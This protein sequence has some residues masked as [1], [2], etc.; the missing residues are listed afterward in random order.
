MTSSS[1]AIPK[2]NPDITWQPLPNPDSTLKSCLTGL[3]NSL[4]TTR[5]T[6]IA[7]QNGFTNG[8]VK[9]NTDENNWINTCT[10]LQNV[11]RLS[12]FHTS[13]IVPHLQSV[14]MPL[15]VTLV[16]SIRSSIAKHSLESA[17]EL[18]N[19]TGRYI[20]SHV[21]NLIKS[22]LSVLSGSNSFLRDYVE[23]VITAIMRNCNSTK[24]LNGILASS[25]SKSKQVREQA[26]K[27]IY[28]FIN[29]FGQAKILRD[30]S[31]KI[32]PSIGNALTA[33]EESSRWWGKKCVTDL[34]VYPEFERAVVKHAGGEAKA[35]NIL[36]IAENLRTNPMGSRT[37]S[38]GFRPKAGQSRQRSGVGSERGYSAKMRV[39]EDEY[40]GG[41]SRVSSR[42]LSQIQNDNEGVKEL[43]G[44]MKRGNLE[45]RR[46]AIER[47]I[48]KCLSPRN[49]DKRFISD[50]ISPLA[51]AY[52]DVIKTSNNKVNEVALRGLQKLIQPH[53]NLLQAA[54]FK[55]HVP[56]LVQFIVP[57]LNSNSRMSS[58]AK[59]ADAALNILI[60]QLDC[61]LIFSPLANRL[62][63]ERPIQVKKV[64]SEKLISII[65]GERGRGV[66][67]NAIIERHALP[68]LYSIATVPQLKTESHELISSIVT[69]VG[70]DRIWQLADVHNKSSILSRLIERP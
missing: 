7:A 59:H 10:A 25:K 3:T 15:T 55:D 41:A 9:S 19:S 46:L 40:L 32:I 42:G 68:A 37:V 1:Q 33:A 34:M 18:C 48:D 39:K 49:E 21:E 43:T 4:E 62:Q 51:D 22:A 67:K 2:Y 58:L 8:V 17:E 60:D 52:I 23:R 5:E 63:F 31:D 27:S 14:I 24:F 26:A 20:D 50:N 28:D 69:M 65:Q 61:T 16:N 56:N 70:E 30:Y 13:T 44:Q 45:D 38:S 54:T 36:N 11:A 35:N 53:S 57:H 66:L 47:F 12:R 6:E 64:L 29:E